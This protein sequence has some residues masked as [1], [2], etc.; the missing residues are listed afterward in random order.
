MHTMAAMTKKAGAKQP[1]HYYT[2]GIDVGTQSTKAVLFSPSEGRVHGRASVAYDLL[3]TS[4]PGRAEQHPSTWIDAV[5]GAVKGALAAAAAAAS[6]ADADVDNTAPPPSTRV[7][8]IAVSGQ[9]H[10]M[11]LLDAN[12]QVVRPAKLWC[13]TESAAEAEELSKQLAPRGLPPMPAAFTASK[14]LWCKRHDPQAWLRA[15]KMMLPHDY[16]NYWLT[17]GKLTATEASDASGTGVFDAASRQWDLDAAA[18]VD[19]RLPAMLLREVSSPSASVGELCAEAAAALGLD[20]S[21]GGDADDGT[22]NSITVKIGPGGGD[23]AM[24]ALGAGVTRPGELVVSLGTSGTLFG[25]S[26]APV[27]DPSGVVAPFCDAAGQWLPL[28]C[29]LNCT[30]AAEEVRKASGLPRDE[31]TRLAAQEPA[32]CEG[33]TLLPFFVGERTPNA[34]HA[35]AALVGLRPG[36]LSRHGLLYRASLEGCTFALRAALERMARLGMAR[37][38]AVRLVG[39]GAANT[40]WRQVVADALGLPVEVPPGDA[41]ADGAALGAAFQAAAVL[42]G[43]EDVAEY[44]RE[45]AT[46]VAA[47]A[48][49]AAVVVQPDPSAR[50]VYDAAY[51]RFAE[52]SGRLFDVKEM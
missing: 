37:A 3:P 26:S 31:L 28:A 52:L 8:A 18:E 14:A 1:S 51:R 15:D 5:Q 45:A 16:V 47:G 10:G 36:H 49:A 27:V 2:L 19:P 22:D 48:G 41:A 44:A 25:V 4:V 35:T 43:C 13:D 9:Q 12:G 23:N 20:L 50:E 40:L 42:A 34:P 21:S 6:A 46:G 29:T 24:A 11:V 7:R 39:G 33:V 38:T 17:G 30:V 32:G